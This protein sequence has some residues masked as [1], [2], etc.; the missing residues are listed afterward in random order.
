MGDARKPLYLIASFGRVPFLGTRLLC[1]EDGQA[2][3]MMHTTLADRSTGGVLALASH[4]LGR[5]LSWCNKIQIQC[6]PMDGQLRAMCI[7]SPISD[8]PPGRKP[9]KS[10]VSPCMKSRF[11][12]RYSDLGYKTCSL[13]G[14][15]LALARKAKKKSATPRPTGRNPTY[16][17]SAFSGDDR[18]ES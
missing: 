14:A 11:H 6:G 5:C 8:F 16:Y 7:G 13:G 2:K 18:H 4:A 12:H 10:H 1:R 15:G 9:E 17:A 3:V